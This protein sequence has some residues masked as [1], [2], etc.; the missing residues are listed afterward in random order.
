[1]SGTEPLEWRAVIALL[2]NARTRTAFAEVVGGAAP[3]GPEGERALARL[4]ATGLVEED[5]QGRLVV[6]EDRLRA[7][8]KAAA[9]E[10]AS[11]AER[12]LTRDG[13]IADYPSR[14]SDRYLLLQLLA[15]RLLGPEEDLTEEQLGERLDRVTD[16][17]A[18]L[19]RYLVDAGLLSRS[20]D[21]RSYRREPGP[22]GE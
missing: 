17:G 13:R 1:M 18:T 5:A 12:F 10:P 8:L 19:R 14:W 20:P 11:G 9:P 6:A 3:S 21:G 22:A 15:G 4:T 7:T 16:D 2:A